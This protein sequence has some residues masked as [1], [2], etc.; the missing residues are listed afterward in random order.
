MQFEISLI[1]VSEYN[2]IVFY[3][4]YKHAFLNGYIFKK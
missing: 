2:V 3:G 4:N 1:S